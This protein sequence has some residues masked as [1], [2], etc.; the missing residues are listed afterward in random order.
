MMQGASPLPGLFAPA[1]D[2]RSIVGEVASINP[3]SRDDGSWVMGHL[4]PDDGGARIPFVGYGVPGCRKG[5][6]VELWGSYEVHPRYGRRFVARRCD[7]RVPTN[8]G[9]VARFLEANISGCGPVRARK[10]VERLGPGCLEELA[11]KPERVREV[12]P[13]KAGERLEQSVA[14]WAQ[15]HDAGRESVDIAA[16]LLS[17]GMSPRMAERVRETFRTADEVRR[18]LTED[19]YRLVAVAGIGF[20]KADAVARSLG[21]GREEPSRIRAGLVHAL[22]EAEGRGH[23]GLPNERLEG[24]AADILGVS[25]ERVRD[26]IVQ[27]TRRGQ[28]AQNMGLVYRPSSLRREQ[29]LASRVG[30]LLARPVGLGEEDRRAVRSLVEESKLSEKQQEAVWTALDSSLAILTGRPGSGK[31]TT[32]RTFIRAAQRLGWNID[33]VAPTGK[34]AARA[35]EVTGLEAK[36]IHRLLG[37]FPGQVGVTLTSDLL[38]VDEA[39]MADLQVMLW[40]LEHVEPGRTRVLLVGDQ[41]QLPSVGHGRVFG[42]LIDSGRVPSVELREI[43]RQGSGSRI[44]ENA[45]RLLDG[46]PL[47]LDNGGPADFLFADVGAMGE[48]GEDGFPRPVAGRSRMEQEE[49]LSRLG[50]ALEHLVHVKGYEPGRDIQVLSPMRRGLLGVDSLNRRL[51]DVLNPHGARGPEIGGSA[52]VRVGDRVIQTRNDYSVPG[53]LFNGEQGVVESVEREGRI[54]VRFDE[55]SLVLSGAQLRRLQLAWA[56]TV[57]RSQ[58]SEF[59]CVLLLYHS[60]HYVLLDRS[61]LYTA[62]TRA[63]QLLVLIGNEQ[64]LTA[65]RQ[66]HGPSPS[67]RHTRLDIR[68]GRAIA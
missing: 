61:L 68:L 64:A 7:A 67:R 55:R 1:G 8:V 42:D 63:K 66:G 36:T 22:E 50:N 24:V 65:T 43:F 27:A 25:R 5:A 60:S 53:G 58:G 19:P 10:I 52:V 44:I 34:A 33:L 6:A 30:D 15:S 21:I 29:R 51:Q 13:G 56:I 4:E 41:D 28:V 18:V 26:Q 38:I 48:V 39:S 46:K 3:A 32:T 11:R 45:H 17:A 9:G 62:I 37:G 57:H 31:T 12:F 40:L 54:E 23:S 35:A 49:A 2:E 47:L 20:A 16:A 59:P 14:D